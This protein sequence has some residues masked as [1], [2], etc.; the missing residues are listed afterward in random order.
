MRNVGK[1]GEIR[2]KGGEVRGNYERDN[3][4]N[5]DWGCWASKMSGSCEIGKMRGSKV[6][7]VR[8]NE[9][10]VSEGK[11]IKEK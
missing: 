7:D 1:L 4:E 3:R 8:V 6:R 11:R 5:K 10:R 9:E 2:G